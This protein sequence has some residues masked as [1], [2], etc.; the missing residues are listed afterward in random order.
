MKC[1]FYLLKKKLVFS[2][3]KN[4]YAS[5]LWG[6]KSGYEQEGKRLIF[7]S[8]EQYSSTVK[9]MFALLKRLVN[10]A[11]RKACSCSVFLK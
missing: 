8:D 5:F 4:S 10:P 11:L 6:N 9:S 3:H 1:D 2:S 7:I